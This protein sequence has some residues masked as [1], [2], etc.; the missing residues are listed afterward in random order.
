MLAPMFRAVRRRAGVARSV[1]AALLMGLVGATSACGGVGQPAAY[2]PTGIDGLEIP[3][4]S[5]DPSDFVDEVDNPWLA[6]GQAKRYA[7]EDDGEEIG[8]LQTNVLDRVEV[9]GVPATE[10]G[11]VT[12]IRGEE[13]TTVSRFYAQDV[14][15]NVWL[16]GEDTAAGSWRAGSDGA[17]AGLAMPAEP[18]VGD[19]WVRARVPG[20]DD[21]T[22]R[23]EVPATAAPD[24]FPADT[25]W[26]TEE[27]GARTRNVYAL[28]V[29]LIQVEEL[30]TRRVVE[31]VDPP[32]E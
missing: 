9:A 12:T 17:E 26:T 27:A 29:G 1:A 24:E 30:G 3:T 32:V 28:G 15:G 19:G 4:P 18:R 22:V 25:V 7:I 13:S 8:S 2:E 14:D 6:I 31:L 10:V 21:Q 23:V 20:S 11:F 16:V 5:P